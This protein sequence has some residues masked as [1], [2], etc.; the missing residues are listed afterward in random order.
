MVRPV[1][2]A[3]IPTVIRTVDRTIL[4]GHQDVP[5]D[6][7]LF[8][9]CRDDFRTSM[10]RTSSLIEIDSACYVR[11]DDDLLASSFRNRID[12]DCQCHGNPHWPAVGGPCHCL[13]G[14]PAVRE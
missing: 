12:L 8:R 14:T 7:R 5:K 4:I 13:P 1:E 2:D 9:I 11:W 10:K 3:S 6:C